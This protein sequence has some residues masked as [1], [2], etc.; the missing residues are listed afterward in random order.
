MNIQYQIGTFSLVSMNNS[1]LQIGVTEHVKKFSWE[2]IP[3]SEEGEEGDVYVS[4]DMLLHT[5]TSADL[6][7]APVRKSKPSFPEME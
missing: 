4:P 6:F 7:R 1:Q 5:K 3:A 2:G